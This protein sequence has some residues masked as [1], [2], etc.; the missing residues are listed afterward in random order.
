LAKAL[1][2]PQFRAVGAR[3]LDP[4]YYKPGGETGRGLITRDGYSE[5]R[6]ERDFCRR[7][8]THRKTRMADLYG[9]AAAFDFTIASLQ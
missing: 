5:S 7:R 9:E 1:E 6:R 2:H 8:Q 3:G 4:T